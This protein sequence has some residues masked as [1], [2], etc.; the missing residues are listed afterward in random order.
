MP[1]YMVGVSKPKVITAEKP[2]PKLEKE[3]YYKVFKEHK[4]GNTEEELKAEFYS[5]VFK[6]IYHE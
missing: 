1:E 6:T 4:H 2:D 5:R 3:F